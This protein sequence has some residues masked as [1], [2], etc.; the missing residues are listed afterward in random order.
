M[1]AGN[2]LVLSIIVVL[3]PYFRRMFFYNQ[4]SH[5]EPRP[6]G[7]RLPVFDF[8][9]G[10]AIMAVVIIHVAWVYILS[11][12]DRSDI[13]LFFVNNVSRFAISIFFIVSG[14]LLQIGDLSLKSLAKFYR[15]KLIRV[16]LPYIL[17]VSFLSFYFQDSFSEFAY[18]LLTGNSLPPF[19]FIIILLQFYIIFPF[20]SKFRTNKYLLPISF[21]ISWVSFLVPALLSLGGGPFFG[22]YLFF[23]SFGLS[24][25]KQLI[26]ESAKKGIDKKKIKLCSVLVLLYLLICLLDPGYYYNTQLIYGTA[27]FVILFEIYKKYYSGLIP[28]L[29]VLFG[30]LSLWIFLLHFP[31]TEMFT[32][33]IPALV[34]EFY[35]AFY[36]SAILS[37]VFSLAV[38][39]V[40]SRLFSFIKKYLM[41]YTLDYNKSIN[42]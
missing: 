10:V 1:D 35:P 22:P 28:K 9:R 36:I 19:Y 21:V 12:P 18:N 29:F 31:I 16:F 34:G 24:H 38:A 17:V 8:L 30:S 15:T 11:N 3:V 4:E 14:A 40:A 39:F 42:E 23:F 27:V 26:A 13:F 37:L 5:K 2:L 7:D 20:L 6:T 41:S 33:K 25:R 32:I